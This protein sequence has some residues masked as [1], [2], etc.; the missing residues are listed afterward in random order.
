[1]LAVLSK[2]VAS[3]QPN[4]NYRCDDRESRIDDMRSARQ[5]SPIACLSLDRFIDTFSRESI[6]LHES[7]AKSFIQQR[8]VLVSVVFQKLGFRLRYFV[9]L[10]HSACMSHAQELPGS[11][12]RPKTSQIN[13]G[14]TLASHT[15]GSETKSELTLAD[16]FKLWQSKNSAH[17][18]EKGALS[19]ERAPYHKAED[20]LQSGNKRNCTYGV[21]CQPVAFLRKVAS[22]DVAELCG[23]GQSS[24][25][26][27]IAHAPLAIDHSHTPIGAPLT[28]SQVPDHLCNHGSEQAVQ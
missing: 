13:V 24:S 26:H 19:S 17:P 14:N 23:D 15:S 27:A 22:V 16:A 2:Q 25:S 4:G 1:M 7:M 5:F 10:R 28:S 6:S 9:S 18:P 12:V 11:R 21:T 20:A 8:W 3:R